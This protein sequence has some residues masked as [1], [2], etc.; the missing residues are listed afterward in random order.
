MKRTLII[1]FLVFIVQTLR[2]GYFISGETCISLNS[3]WQFKG[4]LKQIGEV[5]KWYTTN[6]SDK[7][8]DKIDASGS[9]ELRN[10]YV[11]HT[12]KAWYK[13]TFKTPEIKNKLL[14]L[15]FGTVSMIRSG[16]QNIL[17]FTLAKNTSVIL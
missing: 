8:W 15:E 12:G 16:D 13:T 14:F 10:E 1:A 3:I 9:W 17:N 6:Y 5:E 4:D 11:N 7:S 2:S